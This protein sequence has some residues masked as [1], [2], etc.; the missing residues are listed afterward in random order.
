M[1]IAVD[2]MGGDHGPAPIVAGALKAVA[3]SPDLTVVLV[4]DKATVDPLLAGSPAGRVE[5]LDRPECVGMSE[6]P[7]EAFRKKP[8]NS[9]AACWQLVATQQADGLVSAGN[10][11]AVVA[12]GVFTKRFLKGVRRPGIA[13]VMPTAKGRTAILDVGAN[14]FPKPAHLLQYGV[15][16]SVF[17]RHMLGVDQ[18]KIGLMNVGEEQGKGHELVQKTFELFRASPLKD[19]FIGNVEGRDVH[20][21]GVDVIVTDGFVGNV[22]LKHAEGVFEFIMQQVGRDVVGGL[23]AERE[24]AGKLVHQLIAKFHH[25]SAGGASLLGVDGV[26]VI[27]HGSSDERAI[28]NAIGV[29]AQDVRVRLNERIVE[30][31]ATLPDLGG[32]E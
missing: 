31:L 5:V 24:L 10:T 21:G 14:V 29:A 4:G 23:T 22:L 15:M 32:D 3:A 6:K 12:G 18:P 25:S 1:R 13:A 28:G 20:K 27:C 19:R 7:A 2:V 30:E 16:G 11:G 26:C 17:A 8:N 9:I